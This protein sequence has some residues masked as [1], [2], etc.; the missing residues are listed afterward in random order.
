MVGLTG[1]IG[2]GKTAVAK[3]LQELGWVVFSS[4]DTARE[5]MNTDPDIRAQV[6]KLL[7]HDVLTDGGVDRAKISKLVFG[8][9]PEHRARLNSL[10]KIVHPAVIEQHL[11]S[12]QEELEK[13]TKVVAIESALLFEVGLE[14]GFDWVIVIDAP[15]DVCVQRVMKRSKLTE[16]QVRYRMSEQMTMQEKRSLADFVIDN[17]GSIDELEQAVNTIQAI[18]EVMPDPEPLRMLDSDD[19]F[20]NDY[21]DE[22]DNE[23]T[24]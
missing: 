22:N 17:G 10:N 3:M 6:G 24:S 23:S 19:V 7:G 9:S 4:D 2:T 5:L 16:S 21:D 8:D 15:D 12:L 1:G 11:T 20:D 13:G 14:E 18:I